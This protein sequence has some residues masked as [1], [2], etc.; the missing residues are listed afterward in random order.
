MDIFIDKLWKIQIQ[1]FILKIFRF[2]IPS[3]T[4]GIADF[5]LDSF[6]STSPIQAIITGET[7]ESIENAIKA[8]TK[9]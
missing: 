1:K 8:L 3:T 9:T 4:D 6:Q 2:S 5:N 7:T